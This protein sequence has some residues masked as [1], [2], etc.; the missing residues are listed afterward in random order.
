MVYFMSDVLHTPENILE[1]S[2]ELH[3]LIA[4]KDVDE[5]EIFEYLVAESINPNFKPEKWRDST[6]IG[7]LLRPTIDGNIFNGRFSDI[8]LTVI[9]EPYKRLIDAPARGISFLKGGGQ[10][11]KGST[12]ASKVAKELIPMYKGFILEANVN[13][14]GRYVIGKIQTELWYGPFTPRASKDGDNVIYRITKSEKSDV[15]RWVAK[16]EFIPGE[17]VEI[18]ETARI[19]GFAALEQFLNDPQPDLA[20]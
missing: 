11:G 9:D 7:E 20:N 13:S 15:K 6:P 4:L 10:L 12:L 5:L 16:P 8:V 3:E 1:P 18:G 2:E 17:V 19:I 14:T